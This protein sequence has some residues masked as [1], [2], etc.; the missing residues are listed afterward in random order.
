MLKWLGGFV[1]GAVAITALALPVWQQ[2][3]RKQN[4]E[5]CMLREYVK[6]NGTTAPE[7]FFVE[8]SK[9]SYGLWD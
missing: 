8:C 7:M 3:N 2:Q 4:I 9:W 1:L 5:L 6:S